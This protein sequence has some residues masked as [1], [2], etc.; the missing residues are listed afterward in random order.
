VNGGFVT[1]VSDTPGHRE[2][3]TARRPAMIDET[4]QEVCGT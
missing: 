2:M 4:H 1:V 3:R